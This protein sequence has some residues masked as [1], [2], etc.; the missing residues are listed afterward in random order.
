MATPSE[1]LNFSAGVER[2]YEAVISSLWQTED[3]V[4]LFVKRVVPVG[5]LLMM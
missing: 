1:P 5:S 3:S 2:V 4:G